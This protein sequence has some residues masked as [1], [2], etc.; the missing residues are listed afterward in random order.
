MWTCQNC[1]SEID[2]DNLLSCWNCGYGKDSTPPADQETF[3]E[4]KSVKVNPRPKGKAPVEEMF[5]RRSVMQSAGYISALRAF[6]WISLVAGI[7]G[8]AFIFI[9]AFPAGSTS[10][11]DNGGG[12]YYLMV[13]FVVAFQGTFGFVLCNVIADIADE[14]R[15]IRSEMLS[16]R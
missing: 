12:L 9:S 4:A 5:S 15:M 7:F 14:V 11:R 1:G 10:S 3:A 16:N 6:G 13:A 8:A 2:N